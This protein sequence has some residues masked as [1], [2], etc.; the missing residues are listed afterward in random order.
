[1]SL[2]T[3][4]LTGHSCTRKDGVM[5]EQIEQM[6]DMAAIV[7]AN[8]EYRLDILRWY[9][10][11]IY[12]AGIYM[13]EGPARGQATRLRQRESQGLKTIVVSPIEMQAEV[14]RR[15]ERAR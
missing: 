11:D 10:S 15:H 14:K 7:P 2:D 12:T 9:A 13:K 3:V 8:G 1:M 5:A 4:G 6:I